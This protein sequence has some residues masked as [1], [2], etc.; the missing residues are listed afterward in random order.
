MCVCNVYIIYIYMIISH[1]N[2]SMAVFLP[3]QWTLLL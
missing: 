3:L 1:G 2:L